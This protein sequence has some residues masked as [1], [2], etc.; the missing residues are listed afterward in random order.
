MNDWGGAHVS[1]V[2]AFTL[3][4]ERD[5][6]L[7]ST[8][9]AVA[10]VRPVARLGASSSSGSSGRPGWPRRSARSSSPARG[11]WPRRVGSSTPTS[12]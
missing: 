2:D 4:L 10:L 5:P 3:P 8:V 6:L 7:R 1:E 11:G 12:T 9:V